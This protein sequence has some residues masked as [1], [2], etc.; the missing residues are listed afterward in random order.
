MR[1]LLAADGSP[2]AESARRLV[3]SLRWPTGTVLEVVSALEPTTEFVGGRSLRFAASDPSRDAWLA[4]QGVLDAAMTGLDA[5]DRIVTRVLLTGRAA[6]AIVDHA[7]ASRAELVVIGSRGLGPI[8]SMLLGSVSAEVVDHAPCPVLVVRR[9][10]IDRILLAVDG[11]SSAHAA[12]TFLGGCH[13]LV[14]YPVEVLSVALPPPP[15]PVPVTGLAD[16]AFEA[17]D[18]DVRSHRAH[19]EAIAAH[20][21]EALR[22]NGRPARWSISQGDPAHEILEA[23]RALGT[24]LVVLGSRGHSGLKRVLLGSVARNVLLHTDASVLIVREPLRARSRQRARN[25]ITADVWA[26]EGLALR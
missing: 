19:A 12:T 6:S 11:S 2:S 17:Y 4:V 21:T 14:P 26:P 16:A 13:A 18:A 22:V 24:D 8:R 15:L 5:P 23:V 25:T 1:V 9:P 20:A 10:G 7:A 3:R